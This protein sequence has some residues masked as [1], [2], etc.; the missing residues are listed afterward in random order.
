MVYPKNINLIQ[1]LVWDY[2][3]M[4]M[5]YLFLVIFIQET[6][7]NKKHYFV[8]NGLLTLFLTDPET[9]LLENICAIYLYRLYGEEVYFYNKNVEVDFYLPSEETAIQVCYSLGDVETFQ[10]ETGALIKLANHVPLRRMVI[11][12]RDEERTIELPDGMKIE[13]IP[14]WKWLLK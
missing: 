6:K 11:I 3:W 4:V 10:R 7:T 8:D 12:T 5:D 1:L 2:L 9:S 13:V 14:V